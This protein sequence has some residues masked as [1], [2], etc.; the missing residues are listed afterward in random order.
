MAI[1]HHFIGVR[2]VISVTAPD[3]INSNKVLFMASLF[4]FTNWARSYKLK[5][6]FSDLN[7]KL[8]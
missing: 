3:L 2:M 8:N 6:S 5:L 1:V 7:P 4:N